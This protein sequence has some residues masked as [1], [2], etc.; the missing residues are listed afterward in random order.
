V[1]Y[2][3]I[4]AFKAL[5]PLKACDFGKA[6][7]HSLLGSGLAALSIVSLFA[8]PV[9]AGDFEDGCKSYTAKDYRSAKI[10]FEKVVSVYPKFALGHYYLGN[11]LLSSGQVAK[12]KV[13]YQNCLNGNPDPTTAKY[14]QAVLAKLGTASAATGI[15]SASG[16]SSSS[17]GSGSTMV[18]AVGGAPIQTDAES[19]AEEKKKEIM[20]K[21]EKEIRAY[22]A[23]WNR[24]LE[25]GEI[26]GYPAC[27]RLIKHDGT[28][29]WDY[30]DSVRAIAE[31]E[32]EDVC[33]HMRYMAEQQ[34]KFIK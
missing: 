26:V 5:K 15:A 30:H 16:S 34:C 25:A 1:V 21:A 6:I 33:D 4:S 27:G 22:R 32:C 31:K 19:A 29:V 13:E 28:M 23:E 24:R 8:A 7:N 3:Q 14:C 2:Q 9:F 20:A 18:A 17:T 11:V 10:S 12:A